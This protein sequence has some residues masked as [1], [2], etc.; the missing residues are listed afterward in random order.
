M[1]KIRATIYIVKSTTRELTASQFS[2]LKSR[3]IKGKLLDE[4]S[5][6][7][8]LAF[9]DRVDNFLRLYSSFINFQHLSIH[10]LNIEQTQMCSSFGNRTRTPYFWLR[11]IEH[12]TQFDPSLKLLQA[13]KTNNLY[14][15][16]ESMFVLVKIIACCYLVKHFGY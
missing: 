9:W 16:Y 4:I 2:F 15:V 11:M 3:I 6:C 1:S 8:K 10:I 7:D 5:I 13:E 14:F 12:R